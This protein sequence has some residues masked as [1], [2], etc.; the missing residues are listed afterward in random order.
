LENDPKFHDA[1]L[2]VH[3]AF[4][5]ALSN[6]GAFKIIENH[7]GIAFVKAQQMMVQPQQMLMPT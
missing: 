2:S 4:M 6:S 1:V 5:H 7:N 3:H